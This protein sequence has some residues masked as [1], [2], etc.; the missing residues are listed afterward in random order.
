MKHQV[1][2]GLGTNIEHRQQNLEQA[3]AALRQ[4]LTI[5]AVSPIYETEPWGH[6]NQ[7][8]FLNA[9]LAGYTQLSPN[10]LLIFVKNLETEIGRLPGIKWG[11]RLI[12]IDI[13][14]YEQ[15]QLISDKLT[16]PHPLLAERAFVL[17]PLADIAANVIHPV[18]GQRLADLRTA[19]DLSPVRR[20]P[21]PASWQTV[22]AV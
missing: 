2:L 10:H 9:C 7:P 8:P 14:L 13:L 22:T 21:T 4:I 12:D 3:V 20:W 1:F 18:L 15:L 6:T 17:A 11:P 19:V 5:T 16:I